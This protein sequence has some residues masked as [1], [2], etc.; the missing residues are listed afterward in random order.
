MG[1]PRDTKGK[2]KT[3]TEEVSKGVTKITTKRGFSSQMTV[4]LS[5]DADLNETLR[6][7]LGH[8]AAAG[9]MY[10]VRRDV[11]WAKRFL[12]ER[13]LPT[14]PTS[15]LI[16]PHLIEDM[17]FGQASDE[18]IAAEILLF[19]ETIL[20]FPEELALLVEAS[21]GYGQAL[22]KGESFAKNEEDQSARA[23]KLRSKV[24]RPAI[25]EWVLA[26][27]NKSAQW[28]WDRLPPE[29]PSEPN[30]GKF[31]LY[32]DGDKVWALDEQANANSEPS[33]KF[34]QF[35]KYVREAKEST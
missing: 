10:Y 35:E 33:C 12:R 18:V 20:R 1:K 22:L 30:A 17:G 31:V 34:S 3:E 7:I 29:P 6:A 28:L 2:G 26:H 21:I 9:A 23:K 16:L 32:R 15:D 5:P 11:L 25:R 19:G 4:E 14:R 8:R 13:D 27:P 24:L